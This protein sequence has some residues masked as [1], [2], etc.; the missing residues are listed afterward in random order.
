TIA[1]ARNRLPLGEDIAMHRLW[2]KVWQ[3]G[4]PLAPPIQVT[5]LP[6]GAQISGNIALRYG[7]GRVLAA[8]YT[9]AADAAQAQ[10]IWED[11]R[12]ALPDQSA[13]RTPQSPAL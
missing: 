10:Q 12:E 1:P 6:R 9:L 11:S 5:S 7:R 8:V 13:E 4:Q 3:Q 2:F